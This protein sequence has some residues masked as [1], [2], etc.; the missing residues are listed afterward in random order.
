MHEEEARHHGLRLRLGLAQRAGG[1]AQ[2]G[3]VGAC[4]LVQSLEP[5]GL[6]GA[7]VIAIGHRGQP[8]PQTT[9][10]RHPGGDAADELAGAGGHHDALGVHRMKGRVRFTEHRVCGVGV[11]A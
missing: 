9:L 8:D 2:P 6:R 4:G 10:A 7:A 3:E 5:P 1:F 11:M